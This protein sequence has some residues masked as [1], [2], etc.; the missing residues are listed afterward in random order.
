MKLLLVIAAICLSMPVTLRAQGAESSM[1][2]VGSRVRV[3]LTDTALR[4]P[5]ARPGRLR[6]IAGTVRAIESDT[7]RLEVSANDWPVAIPRILIYTTEMSLGRDRA[8]SAGDAALTGGGVGALLMGFF[9]EKVQMA[10]FGSGY[11]I[12]A[13][14]GAV[15]PYERWKQ[16]W[17]PE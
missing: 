17:I 13:L 14:V 5:Y 1:I 15:W 8:G 7:I 3:A 11:A 4:S 10:I 6:Q 16:A 12:G 2:L 9:D